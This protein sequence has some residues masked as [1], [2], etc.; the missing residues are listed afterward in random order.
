MWSAFG[1]LSGLSPLLEEDAHEAARDRLELAVEPEGLETLCQCTGRQF[2]PVSD[3]LPAGRKSANSSSAIA[4]QL[5]GKGSELHSAPSLTFAGTPV[6]AK[7]CRCRWPPVSEMLPVGHGELA[8]MSVR[9]VISVG[10]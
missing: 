7:G 3:R 8:E 10:A 5:M 2:P 4:L 1:S 6:S 9:S